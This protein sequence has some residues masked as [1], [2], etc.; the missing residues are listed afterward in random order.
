MNGAKLSLK[1]WDYKFIPQSQWMW[2]LY[3]IVFLS[4]EICSLDMCYSMGNPSRSTMAEQLRTQVREV[5]SK[6]GRL[7]SR[8]RNIIASDEGRIHRRSLE[9]CRIPCFLEWKPLWGVI[10]ILLL[11][12]RDELFFLV[13]N[14]NRCNAG[15]PGLGE[16]RVRWRDWAK[17]FCWEKGRKEGRKSEGKKKENKKES[18]ESQNRFKDLEWVL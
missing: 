13:E 14:I 5:E 8:V 6:Q 15:V 11:G 9:H 16:D 12:I 1:F 17:G 2:I 10:Y 3:C 4:S 18:I 7:K